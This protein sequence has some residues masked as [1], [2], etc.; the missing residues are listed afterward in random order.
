MPVGEHGAG[1]TY[2]YLPTSAHQPSTYCSTAPSSECNPQYG[3]SIG[4]RSFY[5][6]PGRWVT[7]AQRIKLNE[8]GKS[9]GEI[10][11]YVDGESRLSVKGIVLRTRGDSVFRGIQAQTFF[12]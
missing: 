8:V 3:D 4:R 11:L 5:F 2:N 7:V 9:D 1:E 10:E 12:G 6:T